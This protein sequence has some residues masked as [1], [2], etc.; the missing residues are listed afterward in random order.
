MK[1]QSVLSAILSSV[2]IGLVEL[3]TL[4]RSSFAKLRKRRQRALKQTSQGESKSNIHVPSWQR[5]L[6]SKSFERSKE[7]FC[8]Y[9]KLL[10]M[11]QLLGSLPMQNLDAIGTSNQSEAV[12]VSKRSFVFH[13]A[14]FIPLLPICYMFYEVTAS[15]LVDEIKA[16]G[17]GVDAGRTFWQGRTEMVTFVVS[18]LIPTQVFLE[19]Y[20]GLFC[21]VQSYPQLLSQFL[22]ISRE[23]SPSKRN[24]RRL[25][26]R[27]LQPLLVPMVVSLSCFA[28]P[29]IFKTSSFRSTIRHTLMPTW[30]YLLVFATPDVVFSATCVFA[31]ALIEQ[32]L[33]LLSCLAEKASVKKRVN[34][35]LIDQVLRR[36]SVHF[37][38][39]R[40][41]DTMA[42]MYVGVY[43]F[44]F[45][46][47]MV[48]III[49]WY[50]AVVH[51]Y[52]QK[53]AES[54]AAFVK[55]F[56]CLL[57]IYHVIK[58][59]SGPQLV[60]SAMLFHLFCGF[61]I[62]CPKYSKKLLKCM[63]LVKSNLSFFESTRIFFS[64]T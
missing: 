37:A 63:Y 17:E 1:V 61:P 15:P 28:Y 54:F 29:T 43:R 30:I 19:C 58:A 26:F 45:V 14:L 64:F 32:N 11:G 16:E 3:S 23:I 52:K 60:V 33:K 49:H 38:L 57:R 44:D 21:L 39:C 10:R 4:C 31:E 35:E 24:H 53:S 5:N 8:V 6:T 27:S 9:K 56:F 34:K 36:E 40:C 46:V 55:G 41:V 59:A 62:D 18:C 42:G 48:T 51:L 2:N 20:Y 13:Y 22:P 7:T 50:L 25:V 12:R 47:S